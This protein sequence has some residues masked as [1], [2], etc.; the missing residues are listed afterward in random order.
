MNNCFINE[1]Y[2]F[3]LRS[4]VNLDPSR[5]PSGF[6]DN[7]VLLYLKLS[8]LFIFMY[9]CRYTP[10]HFASMNGHVEIVKLLLENTEDSS[11]NK[12]FYI[13][14]NMRKL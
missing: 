12:L 3:A 2:E 5:Y 13:V 4:F 14:I 9:Y 10:V 1:L 11:G 6:E 7:K 8:C